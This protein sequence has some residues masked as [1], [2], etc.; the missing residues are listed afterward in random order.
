[1]LPRCPYQPVLLLLEAYKRGW[2]YT[3]LLQ[4]VTNLHNSSLQP[5]D[6]F[7]QC[8][9]L[10]ESLLTLKASAPRRERF[11]LRPLIWSGASRERERLEGGEPS[12]NPVDGGR[13][14]VQTKCP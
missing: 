11:L 3:E 8:N 4:M 5:H 1:M 10:L 14:V 13:K 7:N 6:I 12:D 9:R 2:Y